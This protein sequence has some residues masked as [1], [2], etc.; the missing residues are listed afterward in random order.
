M[1]IIYRRLKHGRDIRGKK[2]DILPEYISFKLDLYIFFKPHLR[3][4][5]S[6]FTLNMQDIGHAFDL[7]YPSLFFFFLTSTDENQAS[8]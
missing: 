2:R 6:T 1:Q 8:L 4:T 7:L 3:A 5:K